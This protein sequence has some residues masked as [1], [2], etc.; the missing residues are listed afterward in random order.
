MFTPLLVLCNSGVE[1]VRYEAVKAVSAV[2]GNMEMLIRKYPQMINMF[3]KELNSK[4]PFSLDPETCEE[5]DVRE[6]VSR[7]LSFFVEFQTFQRCIWKV[8]TQRN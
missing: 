4:S 6:A 8:V 2:F 1:T 7:V 5:E 3:V